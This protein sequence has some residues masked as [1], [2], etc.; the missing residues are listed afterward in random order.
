M[1]I[2]ELL[3]QKLGKSVDTASNT[4]I[5]YALLSIVQEMAKEKEAPATKKRLSPVQEP[6]RMIIL[7]RRFLIWT[8]R[9]MHF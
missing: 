7:H 5:Y 8:A 1:K 2:Q 6:E 4:E 9:Q 3:Q